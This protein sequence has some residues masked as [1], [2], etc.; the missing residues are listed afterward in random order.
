MRPAH[1]GFYVGGF[2][3]NQS[4]DQLLSQL[5][6]NFANTNYD[7]LWLRTMLDQAQHATISG[8]TLVV[9]SSHALNAIKECEWKH[10]VNCSM[11][12]QDLY[13]DLL[14]VRHVLTS[15]QTGIFNN[16]CIIIMGYYA[17]YQD[18]S[19]SAIER[20][21]YVTDVYYPIF[22]DAHN[23]KAPIDRDLWAEFGNISQPVREICE[24][25]A[26]RQIFATCSTYYSSGSPRGTYF[27]LNGLTWAQLSEEKRLELGERRAQQHNSLFQYKS[28]FKENKNILGELIRLLYACDVQPIVAIA[29]FTAE[30]NQFILPEMKAGTVEL[31]D[32]V[33]EDIHYVDFNQVP[34]LFDLSD[35]MDTDHLSE[36]GAEKV[37]HILVEMFGE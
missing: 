32:S 20:E 24:E 19:L 5:A 34:E 35:F 36:H 37:S 12:S 21:K 30:Y 8:S 10:A 13:Y 15:V 3:M 4:V 14:C 2:E 6:T 1:P 22:R 27:N 16:K 23:W 26:V 7:Y 31:I 29:P 9:G 17:A 25:A 18:L 11:H 28:S 33:P